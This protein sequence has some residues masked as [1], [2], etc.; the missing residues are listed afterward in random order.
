MAA[1]WQGAEFAPD[2][3]FYRAAINFTNAGS[4]SQRRSTEQFFD[5]I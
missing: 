1:P 4:I 5:D 2:F 3:F